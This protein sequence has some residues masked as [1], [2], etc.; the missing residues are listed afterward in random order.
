MTETVKFDYRSML[1][2]YIAMITDHEGTDYLGPKGK[3]GYHSPRFS[4]E[5]AAELHRLADADGD[6]EVV[7]E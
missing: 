4:D 2:R 3:S 7:G 6:V 5:E 1:I